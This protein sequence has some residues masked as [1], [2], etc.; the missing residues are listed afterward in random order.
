VFREVLGVVSVVELHLLQILALVAV[1]VEE[2]L[3]LATHLLPQ[4][5]ALADQVLLSFAIQEHR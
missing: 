1:A 2:I 5:V 4:Q 3:T